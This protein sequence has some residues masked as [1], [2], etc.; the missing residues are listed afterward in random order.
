MRERERERVNIWCFSTCIK[1]VCAQACACTSFSTFR[2]YILS[3]ECAL[4]SWVYKILR[5]R[6][7][8]KT[9]CLLIHKGAKNVFMPKCLWEALNI[10]HVWEVSYSA[11]SES[12][13]VCEYRLWGG[14]LHHY[15]HMTHFTVISLLSFYFGCWQMPRGGATSLWLKILK[16]VVGR[17]GYTIMIIQYTLLWLAYYYTLVVCR[18]WG[19]NHITVI[20]GLE[21]GCWEG[22]YTTYDYSV[23]F[24]V[25]SILSLHFGCLQVL[26][27]K[28][29]HCGWRSWKGLW[30]RRLHHCGYSIHFTVVSTLLLHFS[31]LQ[32][33]GGNHIT[34]TEGLEK[35][36]GEGIYYT[37]VIIQYALLWVAYCH[38][39]LVVCRYLGGN[40]ITVIEGLEKLDQLQELHVE[41]Q[42]LPAGEQLLFDPRSLQCLAV[43]YCSSSLLTVERKACS[44]GIVQQNTILYCHVNSS[45]AESCI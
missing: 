9:R 17:G 43:S 15:A 12:T 10:K 36:C 40:H 45:D 19:G 13:F 11:A 27:G 21:K 41:N 6:A 26:M 42:H 2:G 31:C 1:A 18:Y 22:G 16:R 44:K 4:D 7:V 20:E 14:R 39:T 8:L 3:K 37:N 34:V 23:R 38:Y 29:H 35:G 32:V 24:T 25:V 33:P 5:N 30:G 28:S